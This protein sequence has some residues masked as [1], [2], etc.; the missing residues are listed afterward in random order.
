MRQKTELRSMPQIASCN[1]LTDWQITNYILKRFYFVI[2]ISWFTSRE[3][4]ATDVI[5]GP[6]DLK[7]L[8]FPPTTLARHQPIK[9]ISVIRNG[10]KEPPGPA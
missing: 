10:P 6:R 2:I 9:P 1:V 7:F 4:E 3:S 8:R 5:T